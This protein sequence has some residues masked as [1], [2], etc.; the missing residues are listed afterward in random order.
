[1]QQR[2]NILRQE[3]LDDEEITAILLELKAIEDEEAE[4]A[5]IR[6]NAQEKEYEK[7]S[8]SFFDLERKRGK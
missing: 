5:K 4:G 7:G 8:K 3:N 2:L 6:A 1:M